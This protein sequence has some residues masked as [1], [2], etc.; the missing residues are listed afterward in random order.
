MLKGWFDRVFIYGE[1]YASARHFE[2]GRL[3]NKRAML[4]GT[5]GISK[6]A[7]GGMVAG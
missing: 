4:S 7:F 2:H 6:E 1:V 3:K 5:V